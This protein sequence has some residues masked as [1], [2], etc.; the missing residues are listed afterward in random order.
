MKIQNLV[1]AITAASQTKTLSANLL[2]DIKNA[3]GFEISLPNPN[4]RFK[5]TFSLRVNRLEIF[6]DLTPVQVA[7][8]SEA[9]PINDDGRICKKGFPVQADGAVIDI[10]YVDGG[11]EE[12]PTIFPYNVTFTLFLE[13]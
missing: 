4:S 1:L 3:V 6:P 13:D 11:H 2:K 12:T 5:S 8:A 9:C 10:Q 7:Y